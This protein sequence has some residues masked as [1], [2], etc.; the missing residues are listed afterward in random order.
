[1]RADGFTL[2]EVMLA[3]ALMALVSVTIGETFR[4][5]R[6]RSTQPAGEL[7]AAL[8]LIS[9][10][11]RCACLG[12]DTYF[13]LRQGSRFDRID[14]FRA[15]F[16]DDGPLVSPVTFATEGNDKTGFALYRIDDGRPAFLLGNVAD[17]RVEVFDGER[18][19]RDW[20]WDAIRQQPSRGIR[21]LPLMLSVRLATKNDGVAAEGRRI[22]P[23]FT[24]VLGRAFHG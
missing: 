16:A 13:A 10:D 14:F 15:S 7:R 22:V 4:Q 17:F 6:R 19:R 20:G 9:A 21:G 12:D 24:A 18:W 8:D 3:L 11:L 5:M 2:I 23:I 1:M